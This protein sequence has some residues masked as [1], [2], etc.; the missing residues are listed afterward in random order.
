[1]NINTSTGQFTFGQPKS[2]LKHIRLNDRAWGDPSDWEEAR[3]FTLERYPVKGGDHLF[4][5]HIFLD[6]S[7]DIF[8]TDKHG[9]YH[10]CAE[11]V[12]AYSG[13]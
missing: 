11:V 3:F 7:Q 8:D 1:M 2:V 10:L 9:H 12:W 6:V 4:L 13:N 5:A